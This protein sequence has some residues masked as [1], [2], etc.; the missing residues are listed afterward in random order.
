MVARALYPDA[1]V[2]QNFT[3]P[4]EVTKAPQVKF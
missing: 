2:M 1:E 3:V 4:D